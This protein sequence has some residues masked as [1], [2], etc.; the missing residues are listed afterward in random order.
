MPYGHGGVTHGRMVDRDIG[1]AGTYGNYS[2]KSSGQ[3]VTHSGY[4]R[5]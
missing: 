2:G 1:K 4:Y 3:R 5:R